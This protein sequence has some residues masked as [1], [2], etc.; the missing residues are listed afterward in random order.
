MFLILL[1][2]LLASPIACQF[3]H[4]PK[5]DSILW[6]SK[7]CEGTM[8]AKT[9][10]LDTTKSVGEK[11][12]QLLYV[13]KTKSNDGALAV[14]IGTTNLMTVSG[15]LSLQSATMIM[16]PPVYHCY[17]WTPQPDITIYELAR[18]MP[19]IGQIGKFFGLQITHPISICVVDAEVKLFTDAVGPAIRHWTEQK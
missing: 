16:N 17:A 2:Q 10:Y 15:V 18:A 11:E 3:S 1:F 19:Y 8:L 7:A 12:G 9:E 6:A 5:D 13:V 4:D 14:S